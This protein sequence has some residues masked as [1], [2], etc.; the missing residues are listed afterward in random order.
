MYELFIC[1]LLKIKIAAA[2]QKDTEEKYAM[3]YAALHLLL[4]MNMYIYKYG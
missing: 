3:N 4:T 2:I 1:Y